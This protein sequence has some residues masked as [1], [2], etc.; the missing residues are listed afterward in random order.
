MP[1]NF[2]QETV[3][4]VHLAMFTVEEIWSNKM[5]DW[6]NPSFELMKYINGCVP[7]VQPN[8]YNRL[9]INMMMKVRCYSNDIFVICLTV[10]SICLY[11]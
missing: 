9:L 8:T 3:N 6:Y 7:D 10:C 5:A 11:K 4:P 2:Q 1:I